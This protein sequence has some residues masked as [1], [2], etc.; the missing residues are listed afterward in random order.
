[1]FY[2]STRADELTYDFICT[3]DHG[4]EATQHLKA[5]IGGHYRYSDKPVFQ[6]LWETYNDCQFVEDEGQC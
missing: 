5:F 4:P 1:M 2:T 6:A 3:P